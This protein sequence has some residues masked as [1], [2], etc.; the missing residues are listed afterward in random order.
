MDVVFPIFE[1]YFWVLPFVICYLA[2][3]DHRRVTCHNGGC[4]NRF[5]YSQGPETDCPRARERIKPANANPPSHQDAASGSKAKF[6]S[7][8]ANKPGLPK[9]IEDRHGICRIFIH[10]RKHLWALNTC[11]GPNRCC[12]A[13]LDICHNACQC[14]V[15][16]A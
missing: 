12:E 6:G 8:K 13:Y 16:N 3:L 1:E 10:I 14:Y 9:H 11:L 2:T 5:L 15:V 7:V 4:S